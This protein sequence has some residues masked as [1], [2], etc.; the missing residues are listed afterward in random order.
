[1]MKLI[2]RPKP[3]ELEDLD[4]H[5]G[6]LKTA[7]Y[8]EETNWW[9]DYFDLPRGTH[10]NFISSNLYL[11]KIA[12]G[13]NLPL[14]GVCEMTVHRFARN[15]YESGIIHWEETGRNVY[16]SSPSRVCQLCVSESH[17]CLLPWLLR[18]VTTCIKHQ[19]LLVHSSNIQ[20]S[21]EEQPAIKLFDSTDKLLTELVWSAIDCAPENYIASVKKLDPEIQFT[22]SKFFYYLR[23]MTQLLIKY[24]PTNECFASVNFMNAKSGRK[25]G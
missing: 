10:A 14:V 21:R 17:T 2:N 23:E 25:I 22:T 12:D 13:L 11:S 15:F 8:Y 18:P 3:I 7:N 16:L 20:G 1:M 6:R 19:A 5:L 24:D 4:S 9:I